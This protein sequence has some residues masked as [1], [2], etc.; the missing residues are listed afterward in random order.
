MKMGDR[1]APGAGFRRSGADFFDLGKTARQWGLNI[2]RSGI[3]VIICAET[4]RKWGL[5]IQR[6]GKGRTPISLGAQ[7]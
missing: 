5:N 6:L 7:K 1:F 4:A 3:E 2:L